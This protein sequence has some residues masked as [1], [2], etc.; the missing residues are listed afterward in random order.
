MSIPAH[1]KD[2]Q[3]RPL[4]TLYG[5]LRASLARIGFICPGSLTKRYMPCGNTSCRCAAGP[6]AHH[7]PYYEWTR[8]VKGKTR[9]V[10]LTAELARLYQEWIQNDR[11]LKKI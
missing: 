3:L 7:G 5:R 4:Q 9:T 8:K 10:R 1:A 6:R 2:R 11:K